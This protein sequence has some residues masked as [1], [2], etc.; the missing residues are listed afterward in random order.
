MQL[1]LALCK[2]MGMC[3]SM[4]KQAHAGPALSAAC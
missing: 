2:R 4:G 3:K 1:E